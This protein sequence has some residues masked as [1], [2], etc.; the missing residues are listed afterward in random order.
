MEQC[1]ERRW[2]YPKHSSTFRFRSAGEISYPDALAPTQLTPTN[3]PSRSNPG[4]Q[5]SQNVS[6]SI[7]T[8]T[9][10]ANCGAVAISLSARDCDDQN[11]MALSPSVP[12]GA[13]NP[14]ASLMPHTCRDRATSRQN[15]A[16][17]IADVLILHS[18]EVIDLT[19]VTSLSVPP[20]FAP[21]GCAGTS[22]NTAARSPAS[23]PPSPSRPTARSRGC[24]G[25]ALRV[26]S[27]R[28]RAWS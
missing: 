16:I 4:I 6:Q 20:P 21:A 15:A 11:G 1:R 7:D 23:S 27:R 19:E 8:G 18:P 24:T 10:P 5:R 28:C 2:S 22:G 14:P 9:K 12:N 3:R 13:G 17:C 25:C 26:R